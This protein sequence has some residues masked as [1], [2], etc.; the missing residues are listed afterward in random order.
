[1]LHETLD[2]N[3]QQASYDACVYLLDLVQLCY[4][5]V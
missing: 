5:S 4:Y 3:V 1:M 2:G